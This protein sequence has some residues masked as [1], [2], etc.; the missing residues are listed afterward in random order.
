MYINENDMRASPQHI[1]G[2]IKQARRPLKDIAS[3]HIQHVKGQIKLIANLRISI[4]L[5]IH[6]CTCIASQACDQKHLRTQAYIKSQA[7]TF[8]DKKCNKPS[9]A[10]LRTQ[11]AK[12]T[13]KD[14]SYSPCNTSI[15]IQHI[16]GQSMHTKAYAT[17]HTKMDK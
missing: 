11:Q 6:T 13:L 14:T 15:H 12:S 9:I 5:Y 8:K 10:Y 1:N 3:P 2:D 7:R 16:R 4:Y 17:W